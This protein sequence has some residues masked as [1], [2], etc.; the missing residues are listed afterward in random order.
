L[1]GCFTDQTGKEID[2]DPNAK[3]FEN[4]LGNVCLFDKEL[5]KSLI[6]DITAFGATTAPQL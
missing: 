3:S 4:S 6:A 1:G 5:H 2:Y